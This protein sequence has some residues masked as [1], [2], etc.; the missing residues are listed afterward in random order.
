MIYRRVQNVWVISAIFRRVLA[1]ITAKT[2]LLIGRLIYSILSDGG[3]LYACEMD[4]GQHLTNSRL[5]CMQTNQQI[6]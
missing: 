2:L 3:D 6:N 1:D 5:K 4:D